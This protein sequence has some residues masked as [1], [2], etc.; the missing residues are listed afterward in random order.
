M[1]AASAQASAFLA[2]FGDRLSARDL[3]AVA[4]CAGLENRGKLAR[5][6]DIAR[7][8]LWKNTALRRIGQ[9]LHV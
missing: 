6:T 7:S 1:R 9:I 8:G 2:Q 4:M 5:V 3:S